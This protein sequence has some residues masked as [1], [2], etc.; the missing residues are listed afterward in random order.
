MELEVLIM[1]CISTLILG[2]YLHVEVYRIKSNQQSVCV[3]WGCVL[4]GMGIVVGRVWGRTI[5]STIKHSLIC[6]N[7]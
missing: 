7:Q 6:T 2:P 3:W 5:S 4:V 1:L